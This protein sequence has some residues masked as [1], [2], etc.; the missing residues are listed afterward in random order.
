MI[1][2]VG[3]KSA[4]VAAVADVG[5]GSAGI[6][7]VSFGGT[8]PSKVLVEQRGYLPQ[9]KREPA[10]TA[11]ALATLLRESAETALKHYAD[12]HKEP[13]S[14]VYAIVHAPWVRS[15][16]IR[17]SSTFPE[18]TLI[19]EAIIGRLAKETLAQEQE[20]DKS[21][22]ME[23][24]VVRVELQGYPTSKPEGKR[25]SDIAVSVLVS[26]CDKNVRASV[27]ETLG[28]VFPGL[29]VAFRSP[30]RAFLSILREN[31]DL[32][33]DCLV[34]DVTSEGTDIT[35]VR[36][37]VTVDH[38]VVPEGSRS[39]L[40]KIASDRMPEETL[41][42][43]KMLAHDQC[44]N[45][46]CE[47]IKAAIAKVEPDLAKIFGEGMGKIATRARLPNRLLFTAE[48]DIASWLQQF[49][50]RIDFTQFT[51]T[52][53]PFAAEQIAG[54]AITRFVDIGEQLQSDAGFA[55]S[56]ALVNIEGRDE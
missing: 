7:I 2:F 17:G 23:A 36:Q 5:S 33:K 18:P 27:K 4:R 13:V 46:S 19:D 12:K 41:S 45:E 47:A 48:D 22:I 14:D 38:T 53:R 37:G 8:A 10:Q 56:L 3:K 16:T 40:R 35:A 1:P 26:E 34:V 54:A 50:S 25:A 30:T 6:A 29:Q 28:A 15:K 39:I 24:S 52:T 55:T 43:M 51:V 49:F 31:H 11:S 42:L 9:E 44:E 32:P 20:F 21:A